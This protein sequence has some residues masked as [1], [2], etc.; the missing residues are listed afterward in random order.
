MSEI[1]SSIMS[2]GILISEPMSYR[3][4]TSKNLV[5]PRAGVA[6]GIS[7]PPYA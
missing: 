6:S 4:F 3:M 1:A 2:G 7:L 5:M